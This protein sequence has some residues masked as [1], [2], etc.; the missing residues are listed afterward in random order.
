M[1]I[2]L[3]IE[4]ILK[5]GILMIDLNE[6][7]DIFTHSHIEIED[8]YWDIVKPK[9]FDLK[10]KTSTYAFVFPVRGEANFV[11]N[12]KS[13]LLNNNTV[14]NIGP[15]EYLDKYVLGQNEW[16]YYVIH[17]SVYKSTEDEKNIM[18]ALF[19]FNGEDNPKILEMLRRIHNISKN[20]G[21]IPSL[22]VKALF[23]DIIYEVFISHRN[24]KNKGSEDMIEETIN[25]ISDNYREEITLEF[26]SNRYGLKTDKF[27]YLFYK[28][29]GMRP[30]NYLISYRMNRAEEM[31]IQGGYSINKIA[32]S[33]GYS[34]PYY[35]SRVFKK[36]KGFP[37]SSL[38]EN[39]KNNPLEF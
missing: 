16:E 14:I 2:N 12:G 31:I 22:Q 29:I 1:K 13:F 9:S 7:V 33:V 38:K 30:I 26:L 11:V 34:D 6:F 21:G 19:Q 36:Y 23:Y 24:R 10:Y 15:N 3:H 35:F 37:P 32:E 28:Y 4:E 5:G 25:Y 39:F 18:E 8:V 20:P 17:Y 27:S